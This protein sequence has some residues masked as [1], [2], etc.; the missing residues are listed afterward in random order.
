[1]DVARH[2]AVSK[3]AEAAALCRA[4]ES[5]R[6]G[7]DRLFYD[8]LARGFL[9]PG[10]RVAL[11]IM[12]LP[13]VA[14]AVLSLQEHRFPGVLGSIQCRTRF[15]DDALQDALRAGAKQVVILGAGFDSRPYRMA[16][17]CGVRVFE[18][19]RAELFEV[20]HACL[21]RMLGDLPPHVTFVAIDFARDELSETLARAG[22]RPDRRTFIIWEGVSQYLTSQ[23][24]DTV[25]SFVRA[26]TVGSRIVFT[27]IDRTVIEGALRREA[28][29]RVIEFADRGGEP[30]ITGFD[31]VKLAD[32]LSDRGLAVVEHVGAADYQSRYLDPSGR[33]L[34]IYDAERVV[35]AEVV[36][37]ES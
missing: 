15:I 32:G 21:K 19:D 6:R 31:P 3:T 23:A 7:A 34:P 5:S 26:A 2:R 37:A 16:E 9:R 4:I 27:Y 33:H 24:I 17:M 29:R 35:V 12:R 1:M 11:H 14:P 13:G 20:K 25:W 8:P 28:D 36:T 10:L 22:F 30:W 18:V